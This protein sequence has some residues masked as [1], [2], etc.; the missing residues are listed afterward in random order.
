MIV[1][2]VRLLLG[3]AAWTAGTVI[4][5][6]VALLG[7]N[8]VIRNAG[9]EPGIP[10]LNEAVLTPSA[11]SS[12][13]ATP[14]AVI[15]QAASAGGTPG[16]KRT[17]T[18]AKTATVGRTS[19]GQPAPSGTH[20]RANSTGS[21]P[22]AGAPASVSASAPAS[23]S[24]PAGDVRAYTLVGGNVT[25]QVTD[26][27]VQLITAVPDA[28][29]SVMTWPGTDWLRVDFS[30]GTHVSSLIASW[31]EHAPTITVTNG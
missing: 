4:A 28:G 16:V 18:A 10:V 17:A 30:L 3:L 7:A 24:A 6:F 9:V 23:V 29:Y 1:Y 5:V 20:P 27:S 15:P 12:P 19:P 2:M 14:H 26:T 11:A 22:S 31:Y 13:S 21:S 25:L 8:V